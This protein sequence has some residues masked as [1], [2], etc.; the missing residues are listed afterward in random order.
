MLVHTYIE[1][2]MCLSVDFVAVIG[3]IDL[4]SNSAFAVFV[5]RS[6][7]YWVRIKLCSTSFVSTFWA[8]SSQN[9]ETQIV[10]Q[11]IL[12]ILAG[13]CNFIFKFE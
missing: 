10:G 9:T 4:K 1:M 11:S 12:I 5:Q 3:D 13:H 6:N 7:P 8:L 2:P